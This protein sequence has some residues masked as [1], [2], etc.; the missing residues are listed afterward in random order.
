MQ[1]SH[2]EQFQLDYRQLVEAQK[3]LDKLLAK[4][5]QRME[6]LAARSVPWNQLLAERDEQARRASAE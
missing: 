1:P 3:R 5:D 4:L 6:K 2:H